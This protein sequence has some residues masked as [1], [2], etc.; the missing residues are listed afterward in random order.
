MSFCRRVCLLL[1]DLLLT[2]SLRRSSAHKSL[3]TSMRLSNTISFSLFLFLRMCQCEESLSLSLSLLK[4]ACILLPE[5]FVGSKILNA[6]R[7]LPGA[8]LVTVS[9][10][11]RPAI[12]RFCTRHRAVCYC[13]C[14]FVW[15]VYSRFMCEFAPLSVYRRVP[16]PLCKWEKAGLYEGHVF[17]DSLSCECI[18]FPVNKPLPN[19]GPPVLCQGSSSHSAQ[20]PMWY[21]SALAQV[22]SS[23]TPQ[24]LLASSRFSPSVLASQQPARNR[25]T[26][27]K[28]G[29]SIQKRLMA[30]GGL[31]TLWVLIL[32]A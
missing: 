14:M 23:L 15:L 24:T 10:V 13:V 27:M 20:A 8:R 32:I 4:K 6:S 28:R 2:C 9:L 18:M 30:D 3:C 21:G 11:M 25:S 5:S 26:G 1:V 7:S 31:V 17:T 22:P 12:R 16:V 19:K 29:D